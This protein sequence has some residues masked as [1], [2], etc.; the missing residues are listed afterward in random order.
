MAVSKKGLVDIFGEENV[1]DNE[2]I[3]LGYVY[4][5]SFVTGKQPE[6]AVFAESTEQV[7]QLVKFANEHNV[8]L[9]PYSSGLNLHGAAIPEQGG[10]I[11]NLSRMNGIV[12]VDEENLFVIVEPGV[13]FKQLQ[14]HLLERGYRIMIPF[15]VPPGR[16]VLTSYLERDPVL[17]A[18]SLEFGNYLIM[19]TEIVLPNGEVFRT[20]QWSAG[21]KPGGAM[22]PVR[23]LIFRLWT[24]AQ[25][26][27]GIMTKMGIQ[28]N[29]FIRVRKI[30]FLCFNELDEA[31]EPIKRIQRKEIGM[32]CFLLNRFNLAA[33]LSKEWSIPEAFPANASNSKI[34]E[35]LRES[36]PPWL[37]AVC[38]QGAP[39]HAEEKMAYE[40]EALHEVCEGLNLNPAE[41]LDHAPGLS[42]T[43]LNELTN[44]W[45]ILKKFNYRG[46]V[47]DLN[48]KS[49]LKDVGHME[50]LICGL[51]RES[52][53]ATG[54][55]G[56]Y[57]L[58]I[59]RGRAVHCEFDL[60]CSVKDETELSNVKELW[61][62]ASRALMD[63]GACFDRPYGAWAD[64]V[65]GRSGMY[66]KKL[67]QVKAEMDPQ[68]VMNPGKLC[69]G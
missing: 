4:D 28:I 29:P 59:E 32:E 64:M 60:H 14:G 65:Y 5:Q 31:I 54:D 15:G 57:I 51:C 40:I 58:P 68:G 12:Q 38:I 19:D 23:N 27:L 7:Q 39:R 67:K 30:F 42:E 21:G 17:A 46:S 11:V 26:T 9:V 36:L 66:T 25:G 33:F 43:L 35:S 1:T 47:H 2:E 50:S 44:P 63:A 10:I 34:F 55:V 6:Y 20:G 61:L 13:T 69:F 56:A 53:Y 3:L 8:S 62:K 41:S 48:F 37:L 16:S 22:G 45:G 24:G 52:G 49:Q 18:A